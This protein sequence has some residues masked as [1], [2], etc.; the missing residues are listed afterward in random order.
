MGEIIDLSNKRHRKGQG[1]TKEKLEAARR[2]FLC[3][4]CPSKC[5]KCGTQLDVH[6]HTCLVPQE[7]F[8][9]LRSVCRGLGNLPESEAR[10]TNG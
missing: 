8:F 5:A 2:V 3:S 1:G 9:F 7:G 6:A 10:R 4:A